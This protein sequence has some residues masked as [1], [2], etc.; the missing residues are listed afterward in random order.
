MA[1]HKNGLQQLAA[2]ESSPWHSQLGRLITVKFQPGFPLSF[3]LSFFLSFAFCFVLNLLRF[4]TT[5]QPGPQSLL[6]L[7]DLGASLRN[8]HSILTGASASLKSS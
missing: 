1:L 7:A 4:I 3:F 6:H 8:L 2:P 5:A